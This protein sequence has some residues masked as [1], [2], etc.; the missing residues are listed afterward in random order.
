MI[1][2]MRHVINF[3]NE[4]D[5]D[6]D[7]NTREKSPL[8]DFVNKVPTKKVDTIISK[9]TFSAPSRGEVVK[10]PRFIKVQYSRSQED[11]EFMQDELGVQSAR[12]VGERTFDIVMK[13]LR[14]E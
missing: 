8:L 12:A 5:K 6:I 2:M 3:L 13:R 7:E 1:E 14:G 10:W 11:I 9:S 4:L